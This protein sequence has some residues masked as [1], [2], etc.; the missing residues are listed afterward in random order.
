MNFTIDKGKTAS[1]KYRILI[2]SSAATDSE[3]N[4]IADA[5]DREY[6]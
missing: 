4:R 3:M 5:F 2:L 6:R 1:F